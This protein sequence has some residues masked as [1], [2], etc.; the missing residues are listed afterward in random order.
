MNT[1]IV[2]VKFTNSFIRRFYFLNNRHFLDMY[3][4]LKYD[5]FVYIILHL[6]YLLYF[7]YGISFNKMI[8][9]V[10]TVSFGAEPAP[11]TPLSVTTGT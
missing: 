9:I 8:D 3:P 7:F 4:Y 5:N 6:L 2:F 1:W 11:P 10:A